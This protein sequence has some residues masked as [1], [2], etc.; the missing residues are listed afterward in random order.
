MA[1]YIIGGQYQP[2]NHGSAPT[3]LG[4]K[5]LAKKAAEYW[6][7]WQGWHVPSIYAAADCEMRTNFY[8]AQMLPKSGAS[9]VAVFDGKRWTEPE[10][11]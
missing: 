5:R 3:L 8:G 10:K 11:W 1:F 4:A 2:Y 7:N 9:P 6:D